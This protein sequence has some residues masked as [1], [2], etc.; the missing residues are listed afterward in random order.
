[1]AF[2]LLLVI[3]VIAAHA[4]RPLNC[5]VD[6]ELWVPNADAMLQ[7]LDSLQHENGYWKS[8]KRSNPICWIPVLTGFAQVTGRALLQ[9]VLQPRVMCFINSLAAPGTLTCQESLSTSNTRGI[10]WLC[11]MGKGLGQAGLH[12]FSPFLMFPVTA[13]DRWQFLGV[14]ASS[15]SHVLCP[16]VWKPGPHM[17]L[18]FKS[19]KS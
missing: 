14:T 17:S 18:C 13:L 12:G 16:Q 11:S 9:Q 10:H 5:N 15:N 8:I 4:I 7:R 6:C 1:M 19:Y 3:L 2:Q